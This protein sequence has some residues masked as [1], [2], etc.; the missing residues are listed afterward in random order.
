LG[1]VWTKL[2]TIKKIERIALIYPVKSFM[3]PLGLI[4]I[5]SILKNKSI[6]VIVI[7]LFDYEYKTE[8][9]FSQKALDQLNNFKPD[10][11]GIGFMSA[12]WD[13]AKNIIETIKNI[14]CCRRKTSYLF[15]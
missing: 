3:P 7:S 10:L 1:N 9:N 14:Y 5:A 6:E 11:I 4:T 2:N 13:A 12:E 15:S 8:K